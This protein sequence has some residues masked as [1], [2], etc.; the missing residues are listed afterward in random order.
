MGVKQYFAIVVLVILS[1]YLI[2]MVTA[3]ISVP[4]VGQVMEG[5]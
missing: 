3:K 2:N 4:V 1:I 5:I